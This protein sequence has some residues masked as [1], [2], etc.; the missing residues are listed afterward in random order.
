MQGAT[1]RLLGV[2]KGKLTRTDANIRTAVKAWCGERE[3]NDREED[4]AGAAQSARLAWRFRSRTSARGALGRG[5]PLKS[6]GLPLRLP[7]ARPVLRLIR[8]KVRPLRLCARRQ[9]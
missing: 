6:D 8:E 9:N 5:W 7:L 4:R 1:V 2:E 3:W